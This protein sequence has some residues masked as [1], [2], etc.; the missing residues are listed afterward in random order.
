MTEKLQETLVNLINGDHLHERQYRALI[1]IVGKAIAGED[2]VPETAAKVAVETAPQSKRNRGPWTVRGETFKTL[3]EVAEKYDV[4]PST[5]S[6]KLRSDTPIEVAL[7]LSPIMKK[8]KAT[9][10]ITVVGRAVH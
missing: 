10:E 6:A 4:K 7:G 2:F 3:K 8:N 1:G 5:L 9:G